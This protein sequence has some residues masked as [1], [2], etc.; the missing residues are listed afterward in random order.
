VLTTFSS[1]SE[2]TKPYVIFP[3][4]RNTEPQQHQSN[5]NIS[6]KNYDEQTQ[7]WWRNGPFGARFAVGVREQHTQ[8][9]KMENCNLVRTP[10]S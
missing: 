7:H 2:F 10:T 5:R 1:K 8:N 3:I 6:I 9:K 4:Q